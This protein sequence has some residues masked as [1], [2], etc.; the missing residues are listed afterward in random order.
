MIKKF[1]RWSAVRHTDKVRRGSIDI[2]LSPL[3]TFNHRLFWLNQMFFEQLS[4]C[5]NIVV[6]AFASN[7]LS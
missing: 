7:S 1:P 5:V 6:S 2:T 3:F 4:W